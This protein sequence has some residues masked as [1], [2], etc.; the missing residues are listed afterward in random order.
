MQQIKIRL[1]T[2]TPLF[3][4]G[5]DARG[6]PELRAASFRGAMRYWLRAAAGS[7]TGNNLEALHKIEGDVFGITGEEDK[8]TSSA[9]IIRKA[10]EK[11]S[12]ISLTEMRQYKKDGEIKVGKP[13]LNYLF[14]AARKT[15]EYKE[16][17]GLQGSFDLII[18]S[19][20][21]GKENDKAFRQIYAAL[22]LLTHL[23]GVGSR[24][25]RGAGN[26]QVTS[27]ESLTSDL[28]KYAKKFSLKV[29]ASTSDELIN[30]LSEGIKYSRNFIGQDILPGT[31]SDVAKFDI[32]H[33][34]A[35][36]IYVADKRFSDWS[37]ALD[38]LGKIYKD[39]RFERQ[40]DFDVIK[41]SA[42]T[43]EDLQEPVQRSL[44]GLPIS[45]ANEMSIESTNFE[46]RSSPLVFRI[47]KLNTSKPNYALV[48]IWFK[49]EFL[50]KGEELKL[51]KKSGG[52]PTGS[53][54]ENDLIE[55]FLF[56]NDPVKEANSLANKGWELKAV[57]L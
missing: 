34:D 28:E 40:P 11:L 4:G 21:D 55:T 57:K 32:L 12:R 29:Q 15:E 2:I 33:P 1:E 44:F 51:V 42:Q 46:R 53:L 9:V 30:E 39:F 36:D 5:A 19:R 14:F 49:S 50:P 56:E 6:E 48:I 26:I 52:Q 43:D 37:N 45:L 13:G 25:R 23:G 41:N 20:V 8:Q 16:R 47:V 35:C 54:P 3:L 27:A 38:S 24:A 10:N 31:M 22:W 17:R 7:I 18:S